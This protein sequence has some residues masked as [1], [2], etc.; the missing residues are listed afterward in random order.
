[1]RA[2]NAL[3]AIQG[4]SEQAHVDSKHNT[5]SR[6]LEGSAHVNAAVRDQLAS[7]RL[8][9]GPPSPSPRGGSAHFKSGTWA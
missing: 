5:M 2:Q 1:V 8:N 3:Q 6:P 4:Q 9:V 7:V